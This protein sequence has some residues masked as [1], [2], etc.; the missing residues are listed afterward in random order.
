[1]LKG[2][3]DP[4]EE[5][6]GLVG[7]ADPAQGEYREGRVADPR[8]AVVPVT[9]SAH[10]GRQGRSG[11]RNQGPV[12]PVIT[13]FQRDGGSPNHRLLGPVVAKVRHPPAPGVAGLAKLDV[14][15]KPV[16]AVEA[17]PG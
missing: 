8:V 17:T 10:G 9:D 6:V 16:V 13:Q 1:M 14:H 4:A 12:G 5:S 7:K 15:V 2:I 3:Q 11:G